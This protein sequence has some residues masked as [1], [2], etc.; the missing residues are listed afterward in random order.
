MQQWKFESVTQILKRTAV[1][2]LDKPRERANFVGTWAAQK[3]ITKYATQRSVANEAFS[4]NYTVAPEGDVTGAR[5]Q[6]NPLAAA[7]TEYM[8]A[9]QIASLRRIIWAQSGARTRRF[10]AV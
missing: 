5:E 3:G 8:C 9:R 7:A 1:F 10:I 2:S 4:A 6:Y